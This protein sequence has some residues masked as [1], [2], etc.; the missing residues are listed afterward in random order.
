MRLATITT[1]RGLRLHVKART[2]YVDV[3]DA[4]GESA[5][6]VSARPAGGRP[7]D[8]SSPRRCSTAMARSSRQ[9]TSPAVPSRGG[10]SAWA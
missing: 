3:A 6:A 2:G 4:T 8:G 7:R 5:F 1:P 9:L 10:S